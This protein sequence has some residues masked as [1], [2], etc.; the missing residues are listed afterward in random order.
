MSC[1][2]SG[3]FS[4][5][6][7]TSLLVL[8]FQSSCER[9]KGGIHRQTF[10]IYNRDSHAWH[11]VLNQRVKGVKKGSHTS[12]SSQSVSLITSLLN[13]T[14]STSVSILQR[15]PSRMFFDL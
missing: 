13:S 4:A 8:L 7:T 10:S 12:H 9:D 6:G 14:V 2:Y 5:G 15:L 11:A 3:F 1:T